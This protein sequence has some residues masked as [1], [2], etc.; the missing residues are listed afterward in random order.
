MEKAIE[1]S[2]FDFEYGISAES[3]SVRYDSMAVFAEGDTEYIVPDQNNGG[4][5][6]F[7]RSFADDK[8]PGMYC[9]TN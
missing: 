3:S 9:N 1:H 6:H 7:L 2:S 4:F 8:L 5:V